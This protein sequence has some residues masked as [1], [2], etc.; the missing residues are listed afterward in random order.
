M[1]PER[2]MVLVV[3]GLLLYHSALWCYSVTSVSLFT[4]QLHVLPHSVD[5]SPI[6]DCAAALWSFLL[7]SDSL[8]TLH[9]AVLSCS[10]STLLWFSD[11]STG[12]NYK[13]QTTKQKS[14]AQLRSHLYLFI[15]RFMHGLFDAVCLD[16]QNG[17][18]SSV[19]LEP[20]ALWFS[21]KISP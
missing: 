2:L 6:C 8:A 12:T 1:H 5:H 16:I 15:Y 4:F 3:G 10:D 11:L 9:L 19:G 14:V 7:C 13:D 17:A 18:G 21:L 20:L